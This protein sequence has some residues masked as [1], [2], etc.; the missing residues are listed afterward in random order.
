VA[1]PGGLGRGLGALIPTGAGE[2]TAGLT[3]LPIS[4]IR[5][6]PQ[7]PREHFD[8]E[9]LASLAESIREVGVLQPVLVRATDDGYELIA[10]ERRWR[11]ARRVGLQT[12]PAIVRIADDAAMLQQA[13]V[14]NVQR[15]Q[16][17]PL[18]EAAAYQQ[19]IEDFTFTHDEVATRVGKSRTTITNTLR[20]LQL[21]ATIQRYLKDGTLRMGHARALLGT[22]DRAFQEQLARRV[23]SEDLSVRDVEEAIRAR[24]DTPAARASEKAQTGR[25]LR[26]PGLLEL[27][28]LLGDF[29]ET[30]VRITMGPKHG[31][32]QIDFANLEDLERV[33][34]V[35]TQGARIA[36]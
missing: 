24:E 4:S 11:A 2:I 23:V 15:E 27:E 22:P 18:E 9:A 30:R 32:V 20:L 12:L 36:P 35:M 13:I 29:L 28:E 17:N 7:Q 25:R 5:P 26:P 31:R 16:L 10:G 21:P 3:D 33:Y 6:N 1:R 8:E 34:R 19:L 14:E